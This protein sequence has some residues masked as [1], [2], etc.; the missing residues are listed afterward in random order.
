[1]LCS[2]FSDSNTKG[3]TAQSCPMVTGVGPR[4]RPS[5][6]ALGMTNMLRLFDPMRGPSYFSA[7]PSN[8]YIGPSETGY[9]EQDANYYQQTSYPP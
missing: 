7:G 2:S 1:M 3:V 5:K 9:A 6:L 8:Y 4:D